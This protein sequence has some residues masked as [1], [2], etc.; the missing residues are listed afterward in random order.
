[1]NI[2]QILDRFRHIAVIGISDKPER[3]SNSVSKYLIHAGY[4]IYPVNPGLKEIFGI[5]CYPSLPAAAERHPGT[6]E[7][8]NIFRQPD[9]VDEIVSEA[10]EIGAKVIWMQLGIINEDAAEKARKAGLDVI[11]NRCIAVEHKQLF[12]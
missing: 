8:V 7:I 11:Q 6:I 9:E 12:G 3:A 1:M 2:E 4:T 10:V 5:T